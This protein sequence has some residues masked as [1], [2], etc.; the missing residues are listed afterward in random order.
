[1]RLTLMAITTIQVVVVEPEPLVELVIIVAR[2]LRGMV[3][4]DNTLQYQELTLFMLVEE[5]VGTT[6][7]V[8]VHRGELVEVVMV[9]IME[10]ATVRPGLLIRVAEEAAGLMVLVVLV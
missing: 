9:V 4:V 5:E 7:L 2:L 1:M 10:V 3:V 6:L 8:S